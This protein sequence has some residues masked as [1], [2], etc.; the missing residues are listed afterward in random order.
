[1]GAWKAAAVAG[2]DEAILAV[3]SLNH[4]IL[5]LAAACA[6]RCLTRT[7]ACAARIGFPIMSILT[8]PLRSFS[9]SLLLTLAGLLVSC[10][11]SRQHCGDWRR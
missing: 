5:T 2:A 7:G 6:E 8:S 1:M 11:V 3:N 4:A 9:V 10:A